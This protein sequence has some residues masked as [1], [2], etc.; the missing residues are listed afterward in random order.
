MFYKILFQKI[1]RAK[2]IIYK[3]Q[4]SFL[5]SLRNSILVVKRKSNETLKYFV[6]YFF[7]KC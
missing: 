5:R 3:F 4:N 1:Q 6:L 2:L 7:I